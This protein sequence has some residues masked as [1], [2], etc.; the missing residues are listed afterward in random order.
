MGK[1][2]KSILPG[3]DRSSFGLSI[4]N[5]TTC[6]SNTQSGKLL[7]F[8]S[9]CIPLISSQTVTLMWKNP[10]TTRNSIS[11]P[12][13]EFSCF[14]YDQGKVATFPWSYIKQLNSACGRLME[15]LVVLST[16]NHW[17]FTSTLSCSLG[18]H[19]RFQYLL[20]YQHLYWCYWDSG[21][22]ENKP[23]KL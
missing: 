14:I 17:E 23:P 18:N 8:Y 12:Q 20:L 9:T 3:T 1:R 21:N 11:L 4:Q 10:I 15:F 2:R 16:L 7:V 6:M 19:N 5:N 13:A 22:T